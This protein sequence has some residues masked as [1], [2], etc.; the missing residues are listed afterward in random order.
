MVQQPVLSDR[1]TLVRERGAEPGSHV[2]ALIPLP[3]SRGRWCWWTL[4]EGAGERG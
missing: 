1:Q 2:P 3:V 4:F